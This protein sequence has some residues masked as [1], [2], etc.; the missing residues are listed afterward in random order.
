MNRRHKTFERKAFAA[1]LLLALLII[2]TSAVYGAAAKNLLIVYDFQ[3]GTLKSTVN[4]KSAPFVVAQGNNIV[5]KIINFNRFVYK[6]VIT[7][8]LVDNFNTVPNGFKTSTST[9]TEGEKY[10]LPSGLELNA[11]AYNSSDPTKKDEAVNKYEKEAEEKLEQSIKNV[12]GIKKLRYEIE[13]TLLTANNFEEAK[14]KST[15]FID[16]I[17]ECEKCYVTANGLLLAIETTK[18]NNNL[19]LSEKVESKLA[20]LEN[21][22]KEV[23]DKKYIEEMKGLLSN[24]KKD[25]FEASLT[26]PTVDADEV[27]ISVNIIPVDKTKARAYPE[28]K[29]PVIVKVKGGWKIDFSTG[30]F[31]HVNAQ[32]TTYW[33][34]DIPDPNA[35]GNS[36]GDSNENGNGNGTTRVILRT[37]E[38]KKSINPIIGA[39]MHIYPR[40]SR[41]LGLK[42][43]YWAGFAFGLGTGE[44]DKPSY[45]LGTGV[46]LGSKKRFLINAGVTAVKIESL[47]PK[48]EEKLGQEIEQPAGDVSIVKADYKLRF[49]MSITYNL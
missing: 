48:Y 10:L 7:G 42:D 45:Y 19:P 6:A 37:K 46:M 18:K 12:P 36:N 26:I 23:K 49:F 20:Q 47:L 29:N 3:T 39:L 34:D 43:V 40:R 41:F 32:D 30:V 21:M 11:E 27:K 25:N 44:G 24:F 1:I 33:F 15:G 8:E 2:S 9:T 4:G 14:D 28:V 22:V 35:A 38:N 31:F 5:F 13:D 16:K 17:A